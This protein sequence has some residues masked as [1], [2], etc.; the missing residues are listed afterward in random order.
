M[1]GKG[2]AVEVMQSASGFFALERRAQNDSK[3]RQP[4]V[5]RLRSGGQFSGWFGQRTGNGEM[6]RFF[7]ALRMTNE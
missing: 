7:A 2:W 6:G 1:G 4:Q 5:L 3:N